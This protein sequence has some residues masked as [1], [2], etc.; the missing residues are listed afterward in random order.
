MIFSVQD[1]L[2]RSLINRF[3]EFRRDKKPRSTPSKPKG[4]YIET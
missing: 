3:K 4:E 2:V 1:A